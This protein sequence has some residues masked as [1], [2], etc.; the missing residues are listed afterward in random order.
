MA[1]EN[2]PQGGTPNLEGV[3]PISPTPEGAMASSSAPSPQPEQ[4]KQPAPSLHA[5]LVAGWNRRKVLIALLGALLVV[6]VVI[7]S[8]GFVLG[9]SPGQSSTSTQTASGTKTP[10]ATATPARFGVTLGGTR[11]AFDAVLGKPEA[12]FSD[13]STYDVT[14]D[15]VQLRIFVSYATGK[16]GVAHGQSLHV[17]PAS[18]T[19]TWDAATANK[20]MNQFLPT[21][22][23]APSSIK[24]SGGL[25]YHVYHSVVLSRIFSP[26]AFYT[27]SRQPATAGSLAWFCS[28]DLS[29]CYM[30]TIVPDKSSGA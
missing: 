4:T 13:S 20:I 3:A 19:S 1:S 28:V 5:P 2:S 14:L 10:V 16:D 8:A 26:Q 7:V 23:Q 21:D 29:F 18:G 22:A 15:H 9:D 6:L 24:G 25:T 27:I 17:E 11:S 30:G 12:A